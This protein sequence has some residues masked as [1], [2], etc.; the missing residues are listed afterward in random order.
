MDVRN[1]NGWTECIENEDR[2]TERWQHK[3][4]PILAAERV[5][6]NIWLL[7]IDM[8]VFGDA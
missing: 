1:A 6:Q 5:S 7:Y 3:W 8:C 2:G 4:G